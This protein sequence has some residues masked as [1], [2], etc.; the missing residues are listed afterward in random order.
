MFS[1]VETIKNRLNFFLLSPDNLL[2]IGDFNLKR[3][4]TF[5]DI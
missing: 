3:T 1:R 4:M 5:Q 2:K